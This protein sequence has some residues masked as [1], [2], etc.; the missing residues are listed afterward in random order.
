MTLVAGCFDR[1]T[2]ETRSILS[3][4]VYVPCFAV[5][6]TI[7]GPSLIPAPGYVR[8]ECGPISFIADNTQKGLSS[9]ATALT[10]HTQPEF[11]RSYVDAPEDEVIQLILRAAR[12]WLGSE[13]RT[14]QLHRWKYSQATLPYAEPCLFSPHPA[15]LAFAGDG[16][17]EPR[18]EGAFLSA[19]AAAQRLIES[20]DAHGASLRHGVSS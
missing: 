6:A 4:I 10:I 3:G 7:H 17:G 2:A 15:P 11:T 5:L 13:V 19:L 18:I 16:F 12:P 9:G 8:P 20:H 14:C 1:L